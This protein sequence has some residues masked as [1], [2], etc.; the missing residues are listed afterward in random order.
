MRSFSLTTKQP[1]LTKRLSCPHS[2]AVAIVEL[3]E[4][5]K[6]VRIPAVVQ[7]VVAFSDYATIR[8]TKMMKQCNNSSDARYLKH[9][10]LGKPLCIRF[11]ST[12]SYRNLTDSEVIWGLITNYS[13][14]A[15]YSI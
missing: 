3:P 6:F 1:M 7:N 5:L 12:A 4:S 15:I 11:P 13:A 10:Y 9:E 2:H 8:C 14:V